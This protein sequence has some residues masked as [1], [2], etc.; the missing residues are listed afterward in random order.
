MQDTS[1]QTSSM[2]AHIKKLSPPDAMRSDGLATTYTD[3]MGRLYLEPQIPHDF[4]ASARLHDAGFSEA[5][6]MAKGD[7]PHYLVYGSQTD[8]ITFASVLNVALGSGDTTGVESI[9]ALTIDLLIAIKHECGF[10]PILESADGIALDRSS[11]YIELLPPFQVEDSLD[12]D[13]IIDNLQEALLQTASSEIESN[14]ITE[15]FD[16]VVTAKGIRYGV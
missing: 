4:N 7:S 5:V 10:I 15:C 2:R 3:S 11:G 6:V 13:N 12:V 1:Q 9:L 16:R 14:L 8:L